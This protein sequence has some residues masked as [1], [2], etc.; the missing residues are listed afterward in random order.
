MTVIPLSESWTVTALSG[1]A[2]EGVAGRA[3]P[4]TVPGSVHLDL[5]RAGLID[6]PFDGDNETTQ[7][8]IGDVDWRFETTF[9]WHEDGSERRDLVAEGLDTL[10]T[11]TL[12]GVE[13]GRT[14]N[15]HRS[16]RFDIGAALVEGE[17]A[18]RIDFDAPVP[19]AHERSERH[20]ARPHVNHHPYNALR[21]MGSSF[22]WDWGIDVAASGIWKPIRIET[23][24]TARIASV[25]PLVD[26]EG[27]TGVL[28]A[29]VAI[30]RA[31]GL[32]RGPLR[33]EVEI[34][35]RV[36]QVEVA[37]GETSARVRVEVP[38]ADLWW[39]RGHGA[40]PLYD[41]AVRLAD[42][43]AWQ[44]RVG[45]RTVHVDIAPDEDGSPF[46]LHVNGR[47]IHVRGANWIPDHAFLTEVDRDRYARRIADATEANMNLLRVW[48]GGIYE[49]DD[50]YDLCDEQGVL[51]WQDF[52]LACAAYAEEEW[53]SR[54]IEAEAREAI[55]R[56]SPHPSLVIWN[57][58]NENIV[59]Y[60]DWGWRSKLGGLTWG[61]A[62]YRRMFPAL[63]AELDPTRFYS[64]G[65]P[66]SF[67]SYL[68]PNLDQYGTVHI[69]DVWNTKDYAAYREWKPRFVAEFGFQ[70]PP[71]WTT[72]TDVVHDAPLDP[73]GEQM[74]VHQKAWQG[75]INL[76]RGYGPHLPAPKT[77]D[78][79]HWATQLNQ[80]A[81]LRFGISYFRSLAPYNTGTIV[82]QLNDDWPV[83]SWAAVDFA[84][85]R[86]PLWYALKAVY[87]PRF[88]TIQP[89][90][91]GLAA[92][93]L[94]DADEAWSGDLV[95]RRL[96]FD[97][98][99]RAEAVIAAE[100]EARGAAT[101]ALPAEVAAADDPT[102]EVLV[103][104]APGFGRA[105]HDFAEVVEQ[106]L[107][108]APLE[109]RAERADG[110]VRVR[111]TARSY[112]RDVFLLADRGHRD[113]A[114]D[115]GLVS[116]LPGEEHVFTVTGAPEDVDPSAFT[117]PLVLRHAG[118]LRA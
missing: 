70:G 5:L 43:D 29:H 38:D 83:I 95:V 19:A 3:I 44:G 106:S 113:A 97:G 56:L 39:P 100:V 57:G 67:S 63:L 108:R 6:E 73:Q 60:A 98:T 86:K 93:L 77:I 49:S 48:G 116:L 99:V 10:A 18:L 55:T 89:A 33:V 31:D 79:W 115:T 37:S 107:D 32:R 40:Q 17:N 111:V 65:S 59:A 88:A 105:L 58:N 69:W 61:E 109:V 16:Y 81:A 104:D 92:V 91:D 25:R 62:Y 85:R 53:L 23:W 42:V 26:V 22:G 14:E 72:L 118:D 35:D 1:P 68:S 64:A 103:V 71:A 90:E 101:V 112:V 82:W 117:A 51:V 75:N 21:K 80:A 50:F 2:P 11:I 94:N 34:A 96:A 13:I 102:G 24:S 45:F 41:V 4:A 9:R 27:T 8:W 30:E 28:E 15:Q 74:L 66:Y 84:E 47:L 20:G 110:A 114:V 76:E 46:A 7:Q 52:L 12:N 78:D 87:A 54:E 36:E